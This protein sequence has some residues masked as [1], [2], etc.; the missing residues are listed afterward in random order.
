MALSIG[1]DIVDIDRI[2]A[3]LE[4]LGERFAERVLSVEELRQW[5]D[6][7][8]S[9]AF[10]ARRFAAK[11]AVSK[12]LGTGIGRGVSFQDIVITHNAQGA[13]QVQLSG[14]AQA[15]LEAMAASRVLI[16]LSDERRYAIAYAM[17][18]V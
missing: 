11:E 7:S 1:T 6:K 10:L 9:V 14:G 4:R 2:G 5:R 16:S 18:V 12:A 17:A 8:S 13:P 3:S 15:A